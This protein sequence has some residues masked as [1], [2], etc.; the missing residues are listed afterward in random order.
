MEGPAPSAGR[1]LHLRLVLRNPGA[2]T[3]RLEFSSGQ[4]FDFVARRPGG[5][6]AWRWSEGRFFTQALGSESV[7]PGDSLVYEATLDEGLEAGAHMVVGTVTARSR[8]LADTVRVEVGRG[9]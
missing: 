2:D 6:I 3:L 7:A 4:R 5:E 9:R 8:S 1:P